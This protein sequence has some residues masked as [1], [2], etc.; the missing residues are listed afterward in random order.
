MKMH[1]RLKSEIAL[2]LSHI[3]TSTLSLEEIL[4][5][6]ERARKS[7]KQRGLQGHWTY[8]IMRD[9]ALLRCIQAVK[10]AKR[11]QDRN[12]PKTKNNNNNV[13]VSILP[14]HWVMVHGLRIENRTGDMLTVS[15]SVK[16]YRQ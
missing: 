13:T 14:S 16:S 6:L 9:F 11:E 10:D 1:P 12:A 8:N 7:E 15:V 3:D 4:E 5:K 2:L